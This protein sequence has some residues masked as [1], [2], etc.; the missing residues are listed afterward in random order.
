MCK[1]CETETSNA[2][3]ELAPLMYGHTDTQYHFMYNNSN[4][5]FWSIQ[6]FGYGLVSID[7]YRFLFLNNQTVKSNC[8]HTYWER[9]REMVRLHQPTRLLSLFLSSM[10]KTDIFKGSLNCYIRHRTLYRTKWKDPWQDKL[11]CNRAIFLSDFFLVSKSRIWVDVIVKS[12]MLQL[13]T[14]YLHTN[15]DTLRQIRK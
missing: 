15:V 9:Y 7:R 3:A 1:V 8:M 2:L 14:N 4:H 5:P 12:A 11:K 13:Y 10:E 6:R